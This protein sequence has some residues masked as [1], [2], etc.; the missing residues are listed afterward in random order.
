MPTEK[1]V[2]APNPLALVEIEMLVKELVRIY[3]NIQIGTEGWHCSS[4]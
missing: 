4:S 2:G 1:V 3:A